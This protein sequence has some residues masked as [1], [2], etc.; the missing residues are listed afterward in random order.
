MF[1]IDSQ[2]T[3]PLT[4]SWGETRAVPFEI[5]VPTS[6]RLL[7][8]HGSWTA[9]Q[10]IPA[11]YAGTRAGGATVDDIRWRLVGQI[12]PAGRSPREPS[13]SSSLWGAAEV[14]VTE[15]QPPDAG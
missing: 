7:K 6:A 15:P 8:S 3:G 1:Q 5:A 4:L 12:V 14:L 9:E 13:P 2:V 11:T 10:P